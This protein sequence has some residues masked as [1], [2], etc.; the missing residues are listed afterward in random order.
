MVDG[1]DLDCPGIG[2]YH[3]LHVRWEDAADFGFD[4]DNFDDYDDWS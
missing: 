4:V 1:Y 2:G 3:G